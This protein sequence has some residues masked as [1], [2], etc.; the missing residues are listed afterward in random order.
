MFGNFFHFLADSFHHILVEQPVLHM[1]DQIDQ[2]DRWVR[3]WLLP[4]TVP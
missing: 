1:L 3:D 2:I 4:V